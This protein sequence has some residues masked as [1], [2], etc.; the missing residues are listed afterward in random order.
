MAEFIDVFLHLDQHLASWANDLGPWLYVLLF[1]IIF[2]E[3]GLVVTPFLPGDSLLF[4][5]GA[6]AAIAGSPIGVVEIILLLIVAAILGDAVNYALGRKLG[7]RLM[8]RQ[9]K[10]FL[11]KEHIERTARFYA[12]HGGKT[13]VLARFVPIVRTFAPFVAGM[14]A[15]WYRKF[16]LFNVVGGIVWVVLF[17]VAGYAFGNIPAVK[18]NFQ[19]VLIGIIIVS[20]LPGVIEVWK[21]RREKAHPPE[22]GDGSATQS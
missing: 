9:S 18:R 6:L 22:V 17:V 5:V 8:E 2:C 14:G 12:R 11:K 3:T 7:R 16:L 20:I 15:M 4:A 10:W 1:A 21:A 13:V 19:F